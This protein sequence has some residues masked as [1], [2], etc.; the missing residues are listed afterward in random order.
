MSGCGTA[1]HSGTVGIVRGTEARSGGSVV[2]LG[3]TGVTALQPQDMGKPELPPSLKVESSSL[4]N[5]LRM[6]CSYGDP[7]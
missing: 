6:A 2:A 5:S 4:V 1:V 3:T 7:M